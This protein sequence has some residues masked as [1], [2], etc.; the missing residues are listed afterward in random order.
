MSMFPSSVDGTAVAGCRYSAM[1]ISDRPAP[2]PR[3][4]PGGG[5]N[6]AIRYIEQAPP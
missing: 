6:F 2:L 1:A 5:M 3:W 4:A